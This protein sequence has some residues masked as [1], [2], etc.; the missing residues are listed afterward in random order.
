MRAA[1]VVNRLTASSERNLQAMEEAAHHAA[2]ARTALV[3]FPEAAATGLINDDDPEHDLPLGQT[4]PGPVTDRLGRV[5]QQR[6]IHIATGILERSGGAL[7][8]SAILLGLDGRLILR[9]RRIQ[10]Q[11][12]GRD[13]HPGVYRQGNAMEAARTPLGSLAFLI[14]GDLFDNAIV[15][16]M[17]EMAPDYVLFP[18][19]RCFSDGSFDQARWDR[20]EEP[21]YVA[22]AALLGCATLMVN[23]L[24]D[25]LVRECPA[26]GGAL[27]VSADGRVLARWPLGEPGILLVEV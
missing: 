12:H 20:E 23:E 21:E 9:Y 13:A 16:R 25:P 11:W 14:C 24:G 18:F 3:L 10:P 15:A 19:A 22:R 27:V 5:A 6:R 8:D 1:L 7:Y 17:R 26:F 2:D 4:I